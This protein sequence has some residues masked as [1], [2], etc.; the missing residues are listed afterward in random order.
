MAKVL[1]LF[2]R[3]SGRPKESQVSEPTACPITKG[4]W[5]GGT[6]VDGVVVLILRR[7]DV[8]SICETRIDLCVED[9][10][11]LREVLSTSIYDAKKQLARIR[12]EHLW[13]IKLSD[14]RDKIVACHG[15]GE[16]LFRKSIA[17]KARTCAACG[18]KCGPGLIWVFDRRV[19]KESA[20]NRVIEW[21]YFAICTKCGV[22]QDPSLKEIKNS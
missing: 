10:E 16:A 6:T 17:R 7:H 12:G 3:P 19:L 11:A 8:K 1:E 13:F 18:D 5:A 22:P 20:R 14:E 9:A 21:Q 15:G 2:K 4:D